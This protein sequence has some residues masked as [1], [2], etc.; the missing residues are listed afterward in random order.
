LQNLQ[1]FI[2]LKSDQKTIL[3]ELGEPGG[4]QQMAVHKQQETIKGFHPQALHQSI[5]GYTSSP[6]L[7]LE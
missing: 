6:F 3:G 2:I 4:I 5:R 7:F 1:I